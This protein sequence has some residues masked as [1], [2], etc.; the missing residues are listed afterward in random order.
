MTRQDPT[1]SRFASVV[2]A[3]RRLFGGSHDPVDAADLNAPETEPTPAYADAPLE[4][5][6]EPEPLF[7]LDEETLT[8]LDGTVPDLELYLEQ[9]PNAP[10]TSLWNAER[11]G[12]NRKTALA[13]LERRRYARTRRSLRGALRRSGQLRR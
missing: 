12:K 7:D 9:N 4:P 5:V 8:I 11:Q 2:R 13:A 3:A 10:I 6:D 1:L